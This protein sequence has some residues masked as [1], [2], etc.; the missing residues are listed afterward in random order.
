[1]VKVFHLLAAIGWALMLY[2]TFWDGGSW[3]F[4]FLGAVFVTI[5]TLIAVRV[6]KNRAK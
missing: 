5:S 1:M 4:F 3:T 6:G 2:G